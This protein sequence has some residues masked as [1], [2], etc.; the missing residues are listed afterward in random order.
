MT[1]VADRTPQIRGITKRLVTHT[2]AGGLD[3]S[4]TLYLLAGSRRGQGA[5]YNAARVSTMSLASGTRLGPYE[6]LSPIGSGGMGEVYEA[7]DTRLGRTVAIKIL[8]AALSGDP[9]RRARFER[10]ART[11]ASLNHPHIC[12]LHDVGEHDGTTFL[13]MELPEGGALRA[14]L[15]Q[16]RMAVPAIVDTAVQLAALVRASRQEVLVEPHARIR[17]LR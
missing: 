4:F 17:L 13:V 15:C 9:E 3:L 11:I 12:T 16:A 6:V 1:K 14:R 5:A 7:R 8:P 10:E 2:R